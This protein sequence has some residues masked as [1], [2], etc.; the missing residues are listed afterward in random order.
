[1]RSERRESDGVSRRAG[2]A[3][4]SVETNNRGT[5][6]SNSGVGVAAVAA[7]LTPGR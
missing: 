6:Q 3:S 4:L 5:V 7:T 2:I 1:M